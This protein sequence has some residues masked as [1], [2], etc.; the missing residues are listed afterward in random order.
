M[1]NWVVRGGSI[2]GSLFVQYKDVY[3]HVCTSLILISVS[4]VDLG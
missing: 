1:E 2:I 4:E 3:G